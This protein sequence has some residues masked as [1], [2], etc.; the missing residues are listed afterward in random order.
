MSRM[1]CE[2]WQYKIFI[3]AFEDKFDILVYKLELFKGFILASEAKFA[4]RGLR[5]YLEKFH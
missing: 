4:L 5:S 2:L 3:L 1:V